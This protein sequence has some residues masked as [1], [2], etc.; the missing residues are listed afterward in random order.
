MPEIEHQE[1]GRYDNIFVDGE[2]IVSIGKADDEVIVYSESG[3]EEPEATVK[4]V[5][6][7]DE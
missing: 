3:G 4:G 1:A 7:S 6:D 5:F 2:L